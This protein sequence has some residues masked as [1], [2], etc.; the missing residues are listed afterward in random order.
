MTFKQEKIRTAVIG[1]GYLG[2]FHAQKYAHLPH[3]DFIAVVDIDHDSA[4]RTAQEYGVLVFTDYHDLFGKVDAVSIVVPTEYH[5]QVTKDCLEAGIHVLLEK[6]ITPTLEQADDLIRI[7]KENKLIFQIGHLER[8]NATTLALKEFIDDPKFIESHRLAHFNPR[9]TDV[10]VILDLMIHDIDIILS[11]VNAPVKEIRANGESVLTRDTDIANAR[12]LFENDCV[13]NVTASRISMKIQ[14]KMRI[15]QKDAYISVD[16]LKKK[17][18]I[19]RKGTREAFPGIPEI[20]S[21]VHYFD[22]SDAIMS[23]ID[24]FLQIII[25]HGK[26]VVSGKEGREALAV[27][28]Q[29]SQLLKN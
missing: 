3:S 23:E 22:R 12:I 14:R 9:G 24:S 2:K 26:P 8:F 1:V 20:T 13:A 21:K 15:F 29:I 6:P 5:Y 28:L 10:S 16:F 25:T 18:S 17:L 7:A 11:I 4:H 19:F 27:A